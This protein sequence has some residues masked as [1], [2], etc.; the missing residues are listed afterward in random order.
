LLKP[1][2]K[3]N[4]ILLLDGTIPIFSFSQHP[5]TQSIL[6]NCE[7]FTGSAALNLA[8]NNKNGVLPMFGM[9]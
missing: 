8:Y 3:G 5:N 4:F 7:E 2:S 9:H 6:S 1:I